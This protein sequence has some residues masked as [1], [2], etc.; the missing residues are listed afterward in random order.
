MG[1]PKKSKA[2]AK[3]T[4]RTSPSRRWLVHFNGDQQVVEADNCISGTD[5]VVFR[6]DGK[7]V[8]AFRTR[9]V[10]TPTEVEEGYEQEPELLAEVRPTG[11]AE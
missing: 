10:G 6:K 7:D 4:V 1:K 11:E 9:D 5:Y 2:K 8:A 3:R